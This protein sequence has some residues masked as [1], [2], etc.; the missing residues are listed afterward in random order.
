MG[1]GKRKRPVEAKGDELRA[2]V[3]HRGELNRL[4]AQRLRR[5]DIHPLVIDEQRLLRR[6]PQLL[7][8]VV[9]DRRVG[10]SNAQLIAPHQHVEILD[11]PVRALNTGQHR[12]AHVRQDG[13]QQ[14][15]VFQRLLPR[16]HRRIVRTPHPHVKG[17]ELVHI[18]G[19]QVESAVARKFLPVG[20]AAQLA[21]VIGVSV[22]PVELFKALYRQPRQAHHGVVGL[23]V[24]RTRQHHSVIEN[25]RAQLQDSSR[26]A[27]M[28]IR[29]GAFTHYSA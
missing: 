7:Q 21:F 2:Q 4:H 24:G 14:T 15:M 9:V 25:N 22:G 16:N 23:G 13:R 20:H 6:G 10:L 28:Q 19:A 26:V 1:S 11:P 17:V 18:R 12:V 8:H 29:E 27:P 3:I 5:V